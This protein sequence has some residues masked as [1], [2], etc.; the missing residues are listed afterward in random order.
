MF[1]HVLESK[2]Y[3]VLPATLAEGQNPKALQSLLRGNLGV[4]HRELRRTGVLCSTSTLNLSCVGM[5]TQ[6]LRCNYL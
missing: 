1:V 4:S 2:Q 3:V 5:Q 6:L